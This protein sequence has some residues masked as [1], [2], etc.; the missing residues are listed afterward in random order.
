M[1]IKEAARYLGCSPANIR[2]AL[3]R[4]CNRISN[5]VASGEL[6]IQFV[7]GKVVHL[8]PS[9]ENNTLKQLEAVLETQDSEAGKTMTNKHRDEPSEEIPDQAQSIRYQGSSNRKKSDPSSPDT[10]TLQAPHVD[11]KVVSREHLPLSFIGMTSY[12]APVFSEHGNPGKVLTWKNLMGAHPER[13]ASW[14]NDFKPADM[15]R[16]VASKQISTA[17]SIASH[18]QRQS[19]QSPKEDVTCMRATRAMLSTVAQIHSQ[20]CRNGPSYI[21]PGQSSADP[22]VKRNHPPPVT[23]QRR[24]RT[25]DLTCRNEPVYIFSD[26]PPDGLLVQ[27]NQP[28]LAA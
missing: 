25:I 27:Q 22:P 20:N 26:I 10:K 14:H 3:N 17:R 4:A 18:I 9:V 21:F 13:M 5:L 23:T 7:E 1:K 19:R 2:Q 6:N 16:F 8:P 11:R 15:T 12:P 24:G 28:H